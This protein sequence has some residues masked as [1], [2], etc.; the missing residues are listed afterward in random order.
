[1][2]L[3]LTFIVGE[4]LRADGLVRVLPDHPPPRDKSQFRPA[5]DATV[6]FRLCPQSG[7]HRL[8]IGRTAKAR[9]GSR[10]VES[11]AQRSQPRLA[12]RSRSCRRLIHLFAPKCSLM[13]PARH[14]GP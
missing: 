2:V 6:A 10:A 1:V 7:A 13:R 3:R 14:A 4:D 8:F 9:F 5:F 11:R 12:R